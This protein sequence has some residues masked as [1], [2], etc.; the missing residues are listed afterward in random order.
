M[1][2]SN[3]LQANLLL[4]MVKSVITGFHPPSSIPYLFISDCQMSVLTVHKIW[5]SKHVCLYRK[6]V[7]RLSP[8]RD[9]CNTKF[10]I[11]GT[12]SIL[13]LF[14]SVPTLPGTRQIRF[15]VFWVRAWKTF[16]SMSQVEGHFGCLCIHHHRTY[17]GN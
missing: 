17:D 9:V 12:G 15:S 2:T 16:L 8:R 3:P 1:T 4:L 6:A 7:F 14:N 5:E 13:F 11:A 10:S